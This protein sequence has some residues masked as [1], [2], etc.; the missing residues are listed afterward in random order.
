MAAVHLHK[1][2]GHGIPRDKEGGIGDVLEESPPHNLKAL[3]GIGRS[4]GGFYAT[5][6]VFES[7]SC[8]APAFAARLGIGGG[9]SGNHL[10]LGSR[11]GRLGQRLGKAQV[12][13]KRAARQAGDVV[14]LARVDHP[15]VD[16]DETGS[17]RCEEFAQDFGAWA[18]TLPVCLGHHGEAV[19]A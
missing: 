16:E 14:E 11:F 15:L 7:H 9:N 12:D 4:P 13:I 6:D 17:C 18:D 10:R 3:F 1:G 19:F 5:K 2:A 8:F